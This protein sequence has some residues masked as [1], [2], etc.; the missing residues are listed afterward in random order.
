M[1]F[2]LP[3]LPFPRDANETPHISVPDDNT[4]RTVPSSQYFKK[5]IGDKYLWT[6][7]SD[8]DPLP[9]SDDVLRNKDFAT[10]A[11]LAQIL[12]K[13]IENPATDTNQEA[14]KT[15]LATL[16]T[17]S[18][19]DAKADITLSALRDALTGAG[20]DAK[21]LNDLATLIGEVQAVPTANTLLARLKSLEDKIDAI[22]SGTTPAVTQ[23]SGSIET[24]VDNP[25]T[26]IKTVTAIA[27]EIFAGAYAKTNRRKLIIKNEDQ[28]LRLRIGKSDITQQ[29]GFPV[30]PGAVVIIPFDP[31]VMVPIYA[32]SEGASLQAS[33]MEV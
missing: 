11:T 13:I 31:A 27:A 14:I 16:L 12:A 8:A 4:Y 10:Q 3:V 9:T 19:F 29:K 15:V 30:E 26:G 17:Q 32:I 2:E 24:V 7:V 1:A 21:T 23:L 28:S 22:T 25:V 20:V 6:P 5:L 18:G 33:V